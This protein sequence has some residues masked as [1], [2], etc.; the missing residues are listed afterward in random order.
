MSKEG[1]ALDTEKIRAIMEWVAPKSVDEV[2]SFMGLAS[3]YR[4][5]IRNFSQIAYPITALQRKGKKFKWM[6]E[7]LQERAWWSHYVGWIGER[8]VKFT[9]KF[10]KELFAGLGIDFAV[11]TTYHSQIDEQTERV[12][13]IFE[14]TLRMYVIYQQ[15]KWEEYIPLVEFAYNKNYQESLRM[16]PFEASY[17]RRCKTPIS[18]SDLVNRVLIGPNIL[19][20]MEHEMKVINKNLKELEDR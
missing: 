20:N 8:H 7:R 19:A 6:K 16:I 14:D 9:S 5:L 17:G 13:R 15:L 18:W 4:R 2:R 11:S 1:I 12:N 10:W 3:Y